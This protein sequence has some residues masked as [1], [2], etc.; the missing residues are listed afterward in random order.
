MGDV[1]VE[2]TE[3]PIKDFHLIS[4]CKKIIRVKTRYKN[5]KNSKCIDAIMASRKKSLENLQAIET[6]LS[7]FCKT[8]LT[9]L[10]VFYTERKPQIIIRL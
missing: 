3:Q 2:P 7:D 1:S 5:K 4:R 10:N 6:G 9:V 8:C